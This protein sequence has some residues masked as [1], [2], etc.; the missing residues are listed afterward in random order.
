[1]AQHAPMDGYGQ[2]RALDCD[3]RGQKRKLKMAT[4]GPRRP[5]VTRAKPGPAPR[6]RPDGPPG[7]INGGLPLRAGQV[8]SRSRFAFVASFSSI[9]LFFARVWLRGGCRAAEATAGA[10][11]AASAAAAAEGKPALRLRLRR[12]FLFSS[13]LMMNTMH[14]GSL[15]ICLSWLCLLIELLSSCLY[16]YIESFLFIYIKK[17]WDR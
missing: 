13:D 2:S 6:G 17:L 1:M 9:V 11:P 5:H 8:A 7:P 15:L 10:A 12:F 14:M 3:R 4:R 16:I